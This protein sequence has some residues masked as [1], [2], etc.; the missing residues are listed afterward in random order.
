MLFERKTDANFVFFS[1]V[2]DKYKMCVIILYG[3]NDDEDLRIGKAYR[4]RTFGES[5]QLVLLLWDRF[6][7][8]VENAFF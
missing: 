1:K 2:L 7:V 4:E 6:R 3:K 5:A 8:G